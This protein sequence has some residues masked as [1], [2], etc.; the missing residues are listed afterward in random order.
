MTK[1]FYLFIY[2]ALA[3]RLPNYAI[4]GGKFY[5]WF[6]VFCLKRILDS[7]G[8]NCRIMRNVYVG[9]GDKITIGSNCKINEGVRLCN[10]IIRDNVMIARNHVFIGAQQ[11]FGRIDIPMVNQGV[12]WK[13]PTIIN[14]DVWIGINCIIMPGIIISKGCIIAAGAVITKD[15]EDY[16]IYGGNP[17]RLIKN[18]KNINLVNINSKE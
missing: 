14:D 1:I 5:N 15:T 2:Y 7:M 9:D 16:G 3:S 13:K 6:R 10:V 11:K 18:R 8:N 12:D 4:P 17:A